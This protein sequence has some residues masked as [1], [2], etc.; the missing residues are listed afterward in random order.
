MAKATTRKGAVTFDEFCD[1]VS[2][3]QKADLLDGVIYMAS[4]ENTD[5]NEVFGWL[6]AILKMYVIENDLGQVFGSR[7]AF[8]IDETNGPEPDIAF[9]AKARASLIKRGRVEGPPDLAIEIVSPESVERDYLQKK[10]LYQNAEVSEYWIIDEMDLSAVIYR[11]KKGK[12]VKTPIRNGIV[13]S[14]TIPGFWFSL[15]WLWQTPPPKLLATIQMILENPD[16][17]P[18]EG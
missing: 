1:R 7:V 17:P 15:E 16:G 2:E 10:T 3:D 14:T 18:V 13:R 12:L 6:F 8:K 5:A 4:P 9:V 11:L